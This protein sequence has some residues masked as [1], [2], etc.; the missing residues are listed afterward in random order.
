MSMGFGAIAGLTASAMPYYVGLIIDH[1]NERVDLNQIAIDGAVLIGIT[2]VSIVM[3]YYQRMY[4]GEVAYNVNRE[5]RRTL[6]DNLLTLDQKFYQHYATGDL[7]SRLH[8]DTEMIW[9]LLAITFTR[10]GSAILTLVSAFVLLGLINLPLTLAVFGVLSISTYFQLRAGKR[11]TPMFETVQN[12]AGVLSAQVQDATSGIQTIKTFGREAGVA[13][14]FLRENIEYRRRWIYF[15][16]RYE[17][18]GML[19][20]MI[21]E[22]TAAIVVLFG[23][24]LILRGQMTAGNFAQFLIFLG[25]IANVLLQI[26]TMFQRYQ[27]TIGAL[28][29]LTP[30]L[31]QAEIMDKPEALP[32]RT[33]KGEITFEDVGVEIDGTWLLRHINLRIPAGQVV[34]FVGHTGAGKTL[35]VSLLARVLD[36]T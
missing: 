12:Q 15:K 25:M 11:L 29:R 17:P 24:V 10:L 36:P 14:Q 3:F 1:I 9:R 20:N 21:A 19:P 5:V 31:R 35:L 18:T 30:I 2:L 27:Q 8:S 34:A 23:G 22:S 33:C 7:I 6:F 32:H 13:E 4:S 26:G 28:T 16:K